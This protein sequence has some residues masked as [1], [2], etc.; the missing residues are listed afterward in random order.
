MI[1][2]DK[3]ELLK[4]VEY[5]KQGKT[6]V[7][8][9]ETSYGLGCDATN[10]EAVD[11][12]FKIKGRQGDKPLLVVVPDVEMAKKYLVWNNL[13]DELAGKYWPGPL[14]VVGEYLSLRGALSDEAIPRFG[15]A[16]DGIAALPSVARNDN[17]AVG[18]V[19]PDNTIA[20]RVTDYPLT[21][22]LSSGLGRP[23]VATSANLADAGD[24]Y[25]S[26]KIG[27]KPDILIDGGVFPPNPP[28]PIVSGLG[29]NPPPSISISGFIP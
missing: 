8:P 10:Q 14:T 12:I 25:D 5:L 21:K 17:L 27:I 9:T 29:V 3:S 28:T 20:V 18:V 1:I 7:F 24:V 23:L 4:A 2:I 26:K 11:K 13:L 19:S 15:S 16:N 22:L 6:L